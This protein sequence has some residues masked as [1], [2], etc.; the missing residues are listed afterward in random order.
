MG[1]YISIITLSVNGLNAPTKRH[2][3]TQWIKKQ[4]IY[5]YI[6]IYI[7]MLSTREQF[8]IQGYMQTESEGM[9][10]NIPCK[11]KSEES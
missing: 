2:R 11:Q 5:I 9:E 8:Q 7:Y 6:Y 1:P 10:K 3:L 4:E